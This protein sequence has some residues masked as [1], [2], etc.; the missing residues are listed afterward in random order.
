M[1]TLFHSPE[2]RSTAILALIEEMGIRDWIEVKV[3][4]IPRMDGSGGRDPANPHPEGKVP[5]LLHDGMVITERAAIILHLTSLFPD[6][7]M[8]PRV[9]TPEWGAFAGWMAWYQ[10]VLEPT[11]I[12]EATG[13][14][15][16]WLTAAIRDHK[17]AVA[18]LRVALE[19]G[20]WI[21]GEAFSAADLLLHGPYAWFPEGTPDDP[22]I[23]DWVER[24]RER[25]ANLMVRAEDSARMTALRAA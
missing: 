5:A 20:P 14:S 3:V 4:T 16:P 10:G 23:H 25:P 11:F 8:A 13:V 24:C 1:L 2:S 19:K 18:R 6:S 9:G 12:L 7:G 17:T 21:M 22:L 15:H